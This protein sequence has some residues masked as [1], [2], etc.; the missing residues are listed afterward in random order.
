MDSNRKIEKDLILEA[1]SKTI[2]CVRR[3]YS[4]IKYAS[5]EEKTLVGYL[6]FCVKSTIIYEEIHPSSLLSGSRLLYAIGDI[7]AKAFLNKDMLEFEIDGEILDVDTSDYGNPKATPKWLLE[8]ATIDPQD[9][10]FLEVAIEYCL[11]LLDKKGLEPFRLFIKDNKDLCEKGFSSN[12]ENDVVRFFNQE[13]EYLLPEKIYAPYI[14]HQ[15]AF[16]KIF[17]K[18]QDQDLEMEF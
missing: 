18:K 7:Y 14:N 17:S 8:K 3:R 5:N 4:N 10:R 12:F 6:F 15:N 2:E 13:P 1:L 16:A 11:D 9:A